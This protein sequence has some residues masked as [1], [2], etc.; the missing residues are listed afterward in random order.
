MVVI[1]SIEK[2]HTGVTHDNT[3]QFSG[4]WVTADHFGKL[5]MKALKR[6]KANQQPP[7]T[8]LETLINDLIKVNKQLAFNCIEYI[9]VV[10]LTVFKLTAEYVHSD[11]IARYIPLDSGH[12][13][14]GNN[15][16]ARF[17]HSL[18]ACAVKIQSD[19]FYG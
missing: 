10:R 19:R 9:H 8:R 2:E 14:G 13:A 6:S 15:Y 1:Q 7:Q 5:Q 12:L 18:G 17:Q 4:A 3:K 11:G 16:T